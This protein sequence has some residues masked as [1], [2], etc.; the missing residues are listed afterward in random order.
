MK[1]KKQTSVEILARVCRGYATD[2]QIDNALC[3]DGE[4][5]AALT[6]AYESMLL[7][8]AMLARFDVSIKG[9]RI[10]ASIDASADLLYPPC[11]H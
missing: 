3:R 10:Q 8:R 11:S 9:G 5:V 4:L 7:M 2:S 6:D 1:E